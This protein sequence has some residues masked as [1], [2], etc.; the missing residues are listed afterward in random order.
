MGNVVEC[1][2][3]CHADPDL[4]SECY[5]CHIDFAFRI[6]DLSKDSFGFEDWSARVWSMNVL[7]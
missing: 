7:M 1:E 2:Q 4:S 6:E 5:A 3:R